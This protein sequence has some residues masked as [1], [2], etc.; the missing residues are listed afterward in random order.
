MGGIIEDKIFEVLGNKKM[1]ARQ[2]QEGCNNITE[3]RY[4]SPR[5][6]TIG[7]INKHLRKM[8]TVRQLYKEKAEGLYQ[9]RGRK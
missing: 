6:R 8:V 7:V 4:Q 2:I 3:G 9:I 1:S 5:N